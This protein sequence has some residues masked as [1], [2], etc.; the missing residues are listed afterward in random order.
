MKKEKTFINIEDLIQDESFRNWILKNEYS[1]YWEDFAIDSSRNALLVE[2]AKSFLLSFDHFE[3]TIPDYEIEDQLWELKSKLEVDFSRN[4]KKS[5]G[6][7]LATFLAVV[8]SGSYFISQFYSS[9]EANYHNTSTYEG[10]IEQI[11]NTNSPKLITLS[12]GSSVLLQPKS[13]LSYSNEFDI[14]KREVFLEGEAFFEVSKNQFKPFFVYS[15]DVVT[16]V[17]GTSFRVIAFDDL[18]EVKVIV[19]TGKVKL[20]KSKIT[21]KEDLNEITLL[22]NQAASFDRNEKLFGEVL[23][24][25]EDEEIES[26]LTQIDKLSFEFVDTPINQIFLTIQDIYN[27]RIEFPEELLKNCFVTTSLSDVPLPEKLKIL[28]FSIGNNT[29]YELVGNKIIINSEGCK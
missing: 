25:E 8:L 3:E 20:R 13:K 23:Q 1:A 2:N 18:D 4:S 22:P 27:L 24:V 15:N 14:V 29:N 9:D 16:H 12:D 21:D 28:C 26:D 17:Y 7:V 19:K 10:L 5:L 11:N 6:L